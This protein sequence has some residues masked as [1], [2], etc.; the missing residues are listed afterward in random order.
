MV[1]TLPVRTLEPSFPEAEIEVSDPSLG[2]FAR[3]LRLARARA[4]GRVRPV[5]AVVSGHEPQL[6]LVALRERAE[7]VVLVFPDEAL[8][9]VQEA[10]LR[11]VLAFVDLTLVPEETA[12]DRAV[13]AGADPD[14]VACGDEPVEDRLLA[15]PRRGTDRAA[16]AEALTSVTL[17]A[18]SGLGLL[19]LLE[20]LTK[21]RGVNVVNYHRV[22]PVE[23]HRT[24]GRPQ[25][26][27]PAPIF[28]AQLEAMQR[29]FGYTGIERVNDASARGRVAVTFD[30]GYEDNYR[31]AFPLLRDFEVP[32]CIF[33]ATNLVG[34][35]DAAFWDR[36]STALFSYWRAG[37]RRPVPEALPSVATRLEDAQ[38]V[39]EARDIITKVLSALNDMSPEA[40]QAAIAAAESLADAQHAQRTMLS[41]D[42]IQEMAQRG[43]SFGSHTKNH[44]CLDE[45]SAETARDEL[46]GGHE[47]L[48]QRLPDNVPGPS[49]V[50]LPRGKLGPFREDELRTQGFQQ[51][52]TTEARTNRPGAAK[53]FVHRR[54]GKMLTLR[55]RHHEGK[56]RLELTGIPDRLRR[57]LGIR[58]D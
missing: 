30:D 20:R 10:S 57:M 55:G 39:S 41:W 19:S 11:A 22:L 32:A 4:E 46:L 43:I 9:A 58:A 21:T 36:V 8:G 40:R 12:C 13:R 6:V 54:D 17:D 56:L 31:V 49:T 5:L 18:A 38:S 45:V 42:E 28:E 44:V 25:M 26:A 15:E 23:E 27:L 37:A 47:A 1:T 33:V 7:R 35:E 48:R 50:A 52:M 53:L 2:A 51:V 24:Y 34:S 29:H 14:R 16:V 3:A